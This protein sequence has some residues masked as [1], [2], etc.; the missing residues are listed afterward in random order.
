MSPGQ[1]RLAAIA[2]T[3]ADQSFVMNYVDQV[4]TSGTTNAA[5]KQAMWVVNQSPGQAGNQSVAIPNMQLMSNDILQQL[6]GQ[7]GAGG[8]ASKTSRLL[9]KSYETAMQIRNISTGDI[10]FWEYRCRARQ[11][12]DGSGNT[13]IANIV[14]NGF[15]DASATSGT[16]GAVSTSPITATTIG[17]TPF[18]NPRF[19]GAV[20]VLKVKKWTLKPNGLK[21]LKYTTKKLRMVKAENFMFAAVPDPDGSTALIRQVSRGQSFSLFVMHGTFA[22]NTAA[23]ANFQVG[24]GNADVG[25][26]ATIKVHY[27]VIEQKAVQTAATT[28]AAGFTAGACYYPATVVQ[29]SPMSV[30]TAGTGV[31]A[32]ATDGPVVIDDVMLG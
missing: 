29:N 9:V 26:L 30:L 25:I 23:N 1:V 10:E 6:L 19:T 16:S 4:A 24:Y 18:N 21:K 7:V 31:R 17:A 32:Q 8:A 27:A 15:A 22:S 13:A 5:A 20:K 2:K 11:D 3:V 12:L 14:A 28:A